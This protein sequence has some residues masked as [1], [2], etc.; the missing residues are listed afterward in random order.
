M[1]VLACAHW[2]VCIQHRIVFTM[3]P[4]VWL[5]QYNL[6]VGKYSSVAA[7][8]GDFDLLL[9]NAK[10]FYLVSIYMYS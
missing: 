3:F 9:K 7:F 8:L 1:C 5:Q 10:F 2:Y 6:K 4:S